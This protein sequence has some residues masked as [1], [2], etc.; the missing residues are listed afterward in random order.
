MAQSLGGFQV[1]PLAI[2][3]ATNLACGGLALATAEDD[4]AAEFVDA[5]VAEMEAVACP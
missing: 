3:K 5:A 4:V 2:L 1:R